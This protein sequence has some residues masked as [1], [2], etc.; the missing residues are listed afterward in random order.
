MFSSR[1]NRSQLWLGPAAFVNH[2]CQPNCEFTINCDGDAR[3]SLEARVDIKKGDEIFIFYGKHFFDANNANCECF[4]CELLGQG[5][6][7][8]AFV[9]GNGTA[10]VPNGHHADDKNVSL[11]TANSDENAEKNEAKP[12]TE[13]DIQE[14]LRQ[15][16]I[17][18]PAS[19]R[20]STG[21]K[22]FSEVQL[23][24]LENPSLPPT[25]AVMNGILAKGISVGLAQKGTPQNYS[26]RH[27]GSRLNRVKAKI[28]SEMARAFLSRVKPLA[29]P[30]RRLRGP[31][32][33]G[34]TKC[35]ASCPSISCSVKST[36]IRKMT[37]DDPPKTQ[38][39]PPPPTRYSLRSQTTPSPDKDASTTART[40]IVVGAPPLGLRRKIPPPPPLVNEFIDLVECCDE[41]D[42]RGGQSEGQ[43]S[44][45]AVTRPDSTPPPDLDQMEEG[46]G[47]SPA[48]DHLSEVPQL[49][50]PACLST[51]SVH[52]TT[53]SGSDTPKTSACTAGSVASSLCDCSRE[54]WTSE[55]T[56]S[57]R[58]LTMVTAATASELST[59]ASAPTTVSRS[60]SS[61]GVRSR[62][63]TNY[64]AKLIASVDAAAPMN[65]YFLRNRKP[66]THTKPAPA[67]PVNSPHRSPPPPPR[68]PACFY[69]D[70]PS[71][72]SSS[73]TCPAVDPECV[74][75]RD[76]LV[77]VCKRSRAGSTDPSS[78]LSHASSEA[79]WFVERSPP[80]LLD[81]TSLYRPMSTTAGSNKRRHSRRQQRHHLHKP[82]RA[83]L[84][85]ASAGRDPQTGRF[86]SRS[87]SSSRPR[88]VM[89][90]EEGA[91]DTSPLTCNFEL[92]ERR[93]ASLAGLPRTSSQSSCLTCYSLAS[94]AVGDEQVSDKMTTAAAQFALSSFVSNGCP[95]V[96]TYQASS[97][98][99]CPTPVV[100]CRPT[101]RRHKFSSPR[102]GVIFGASASSS[103]LSARKTFLF[104]SQLRR[105]T[106]SLWTTAA[107]TCSSLLNTPSP[108]HLQPALTPPPPI[109]QEP[110]GFPCG[111]GG[112]R[113]LSP[114]SSSSPIT[115]PECCSCPPLY[116]D[117]PDSPSLTNQ[118]L[119]RT[120]AIKQDLHLCLNGS[121]GSSGHAS[122]TDLTA[123]QIKP[124]TVTIKRLGQKL[125]CVSG[126]DMEEAM[127]TVPVDQGQEANFL[128]SH[129]H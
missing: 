96:R 16:L 27:T 94:P 128:E 83:L 24:S 125:Y 40:P 30:V 52:S 97:S 28:Y 105:Q 48:A 117:G 93:T 82:G 129:L 2:D 46:G 20:T 76:R 85:T 45:T 11:S 41:D 7:S 68:R 56:D 108:P 13:D 23:M 57:T 104:R 126:Y 112:S 78:P 86:L 36:R 81:V 51:P 102:S 120:Q 5:Y 98:L 95:P 77:L 66:K 110:D 59:P 115:A 87:R 1:K 14:T 122:P 49:S 70:S 79:E 4:T 106:R 58:T 37:R 65:T 69:L 9:E 64:D 109:L 38:P 113:C 123:L 124:L 63:L 53:M 3:M 60:R 71:S 55:S 10:A 22:I 47:R 119:E 74:P 15:R 54:L 29:K 67:P 90:A 121:T 111:G 72:T 33:T 103:A 101:H 114:S 84:P 50:Y 107:T 25:A 42:A 127:T 18:I 17:R 43:T 21:G 88:V 99:R 31:R 8:Q 6:F 44:T 61:V 75:P 116:P 92:S 34:T 32:T 100:L 118:G 26:L 62:R 19:R 12:A 80:P 39:P 35:S 73:A 91:G 89:E